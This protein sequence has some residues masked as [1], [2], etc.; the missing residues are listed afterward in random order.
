METTGAIDQA[1]DLYRLPRKVDAYRSQP[2]PAD[3]N[4]LLQ[5]L[6][7]DPDDAVALPLDQFNIDASPSEV[8]GFYIEQIML[9]PGSS[10]Y[11]TLGAFEDDSRETLRSN[12]AL[13]LRWLHPD[14]NSDEDRTIF[15][16]RVL[17]AWEM[18]KTPARRKAYDLKLREGRRRKASQPPQ[19]EPVITSLAAAGVSSPPVY[20][21]LPARTAY[22]SSRSP[23]SRIAAFGLS[24]LRWSRRLLVVA[25][26]GVIL[27]YLYEPNEMLSITEIYWRQLIQWLNYT[28]I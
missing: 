3:V 9:F 26:A 6:A 11:R 14:R 7:N 16:N 8:L 13:L 18:V 4:V 17:E 23:R 1:L 19:S 21:N 2:L 24:V 5:A 27:L 25:G 10:A 20:R 15:A 12:M 28:V 22:R